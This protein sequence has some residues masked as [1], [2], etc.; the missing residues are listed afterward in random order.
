ML[1]ATSVL[2]P[3][4]LALGVLPLG[5][6]AEGHVPVLLWSTRS[7]LWDRTALA[8]EGHITS[9]REFHAFLEPI[10]HQNPR[11]LVLFLQDSLSVDDFTYLSATSER[12]KPLH[13]IQE[14]LNSSESSLVLPAVAWEAVRHLA[15]YLQKKADW[16]LM[17]MNDVDASGFTPSVS[18]PNLIVVT[19]QSTTRGS[20]IPAAWSVVENEEKIGRLTEFLRG[21]AMEFSAIYS[22][23]KPSK[24]HRSF[25]EISARRRRLMAESAVATVPYP[26]LNVTNGTDTCIIFYATNISL[27]VNETIHLDVTNQTFITRAA[28]TSS[29]S[30]STG[31]TTLSLKYYNLTADIR[32]LEIRF[33]MSNQFYAGSARNWF[34]VDRVQIIANDNAP[35]A[36]FSIPYASSPAEYS[37][38]CQLVGTSALYGAVMTPSNAAA[39]SWNVL[40][41]EFQIQGFHVQNSLFSYASDCTGFFS[42]PIWMALVSSLVLLWILAYGIYMLMQLTT[43]DKFDDPRGQPLSVSLME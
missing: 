6:V 19:L 43:N 39:K 15:D 23:L 10:L 25:D 17:Y 38:H 3:L 41:S 20:G 34:T 11:N 5:A 21:K 30:C 8:H 18:K 7:S 27:T 28:D 24:I 2:C 14:V 42:A 9:G 32:S 33:A 12:E 37:F 22:A 35:G 16:H 13:N 29:S 26:P 40:I 36:L 1:P 31:N 4:L